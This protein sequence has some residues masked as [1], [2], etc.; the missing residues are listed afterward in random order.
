MK[1]ILFSAFIAF[2][3]VATSC[4]KEPIEI[5]TDANEYTDTPPAALF[6]RYTDYGTIQNYW[7]DKTVID[8]FTVKNACQFWTNW[9]GD[10]HYDNCGDWRR[11]SAYVYWG[12]INGKNYFSAGKNYV[13][14]SPDAFLR[15]GEIVNR[16]KDAIGEYCEGCNL[17][18][19]SKGLISWVR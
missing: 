5:Y 17:T 2:M 14:I 10:T 15:A 12:R 3:F 4:T 18:T 1:K 16:R 11:I 7:I 6:D 19:G 8:S 13:W 9:N